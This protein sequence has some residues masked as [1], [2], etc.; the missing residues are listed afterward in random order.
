VEF[1]VDKVALGQVFYQ[2]FGF[3]MSISF[4]WFSITWKNEKRIVF[5]TGL[6]NKPEG[7][8]ASVA[9][10]AVSFTTHTNKEDYTFKFAH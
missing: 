7:C 9:S 2:Y 1:V 10:A 5:I 4:H 3:P 6:H 8:C